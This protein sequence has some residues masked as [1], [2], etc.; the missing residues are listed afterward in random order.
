MVQRRQWILQIHPCGTG[1]KSHRFH[2]AWH[3]S[4]RKL[5][6]VAWRHLLNVPCLQDRRSSANTVLLLSLNLNSAGNY[7]CEVSAEAPLFNT[8]SQRSRME[9]IVLPNSPPRISGAKPTYHVGDLVQVNCTSDKS[10]P[11]ASLHWYINGREVRLVFICF[12]GS[13]CHLNYGRSRSFVLLFRHR[14]LCFVHI[15]QFSTRTV[16]RLPSRAWNSGWPSP[17]FST[18]LEV[19]A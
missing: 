17:L 4:W 5:S 8:V 3:Q 6:K 19:W 11:A 2:H 10:K 12:W 9:I 15:S 7:R 16:W 18:N 1:S 13:K 14:P